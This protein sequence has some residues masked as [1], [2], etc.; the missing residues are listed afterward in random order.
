MIFIISPSKDLDFK[1]PSPLISNDYSRLWNKSLDL[2]KVMKSKKPK[3]LKK[4]MS[5][6]DKLAEE[7]VLRYQKMGDECNM[8]N[9]KPAIYAFNGDVY[10]G[11]K[12]LNFDQSEIDYCQKNLR[13]LSGFY[14]L[15]R[16]LDLIQPYRLEMGIALKVNKAKNI[17]QFWGLDITKL[18]IQD[19]E[20]GESKYLINLASKEYFK[21]ILCD[22]IQIPII[23]IHFREMRN[24]KLIFVSYN[25]KKARGLMVH[26]AA[27]NKVKNLEE[28]CIFNLENYSF[29]PKLSNSKELF[30]V[31]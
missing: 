29:D 22:S 24:G 17:Y 10:I 28:L 9:S 25:A 8:E 7:N 4:L 19:I 3:D 16:P 6:S 31:R 11:L 27:K 13:I 20:Y 30:F 5:I 18:L 14:G 1:N 15:L 23:D 2:L 12:A 21:S 26:F